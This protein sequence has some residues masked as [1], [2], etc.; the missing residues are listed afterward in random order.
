MAIGRGDILSYIYCYKFIN[1]LSTLKEQ[2][3]RQILTTGNTINIMQSVLLRYE[4]TRYED[5]WLE[6]ASGACQGLFR[7]VSVE[8]LL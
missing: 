6:P 3:P 8:L 4:R 5:T 7:Y 1:C 2:Q